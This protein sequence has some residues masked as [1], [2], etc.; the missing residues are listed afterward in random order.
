MKYVSPQA[1]HEILVN[2]RRLI[3]KNKFIQRMGGQDSQRALDV[4]KGARE[5]Q[6]P[7]ISYRYWKEM[8]GEV[9]SRAL[10]EIKAPEWKKE[11]GAAVGM[12]VV[13]VPAGSGPLYYPKEG[14]LGL[15]MEAGMALQLMAHY[16]PEVCHSAQA[17]LE[18]L[19]QGKEIPKA[20]PQATAGALFILH[21]SSRGLDGM[22]EDLSLQD[23]FVKR[24][25]RANGGKYVEQV[26]AEMRVIQFNYLA[27]AHDGSQAN[28]I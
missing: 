24:L 19:L 13:E 8:S 2:P 27:Y 22:F 9:E 4:W 17:T 16:M 5:V 25:A 18:A 1:L 7:I 6:L 26:Q 20:W 23:Q 21:L 14:Q 10:D 11:I 3:G 28:I 15:N 12:K